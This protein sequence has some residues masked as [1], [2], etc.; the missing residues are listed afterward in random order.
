MSGP[1]R[2]PGLVRTKNSA[3]SYPLGEISVSSRF[4]STL[5]SARSSLS[6]ANSAPTAL[7]SSSAFVSR[8]ALSVLAAVW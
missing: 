3:R 2:E 8:A 7:A 1:G 6:G 4:K 5:N